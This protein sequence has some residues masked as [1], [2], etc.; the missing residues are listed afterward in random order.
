MVKSENLK[1]RE[2]YKIV[3]EEIIKFKNLIKGHEKILEA[4]GSL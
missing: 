4:I 1:D 3:S 2:K